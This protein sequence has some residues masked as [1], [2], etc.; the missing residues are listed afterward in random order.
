MRL[1]LQP[2]TSAIASELTGSGAMSEVVITM[3]KA[4]ALTV[5]GIGLFVLGIV[6]ANFYGWAY[7][8]LVVVGACTAGIGHTLAWKE[9]S[10]W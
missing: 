1:R 8:S 9:S 6:L 7:F 10:K 5:F 4:A 3:K 2:E